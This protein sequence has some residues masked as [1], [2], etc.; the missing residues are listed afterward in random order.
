MLSEIRF[1]NLW[2]DL[3]M[4]FLIVLCNDMC[5]RYLA[6]RLSFQTRFALYRKLTRQTAN[7]LQIK[8]IYWLCF[9]ND[10]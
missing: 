8:V 4:K 2:E 5:F 10:G 9:L 1:L 3:Y 6:V 7:P